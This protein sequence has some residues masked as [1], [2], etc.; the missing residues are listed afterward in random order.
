MLFCNTERCVPAE[1]LVDPLGHQ[2]LLPVLRRR[3]VSVALDRVEAVAGARCR[4]I[5]LTTSIPDW[6][7]AVAKAGAMTAPGG[8]RLVVGLGT[9][10]SSARAEQALDAGAAFLVSPFLAAAVQP[11]AD[12][13]GAILIE[14]R[15]PPGEVAAAASKRLAKVFPARIGGPVD[16]EPQR[17]PH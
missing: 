11:V 8:S 2:R 5:E 10:S 17:R 16:P 12:R 15:P 13:R 14:G 4:A 1:D 7:E 3:S 6:H 9:V